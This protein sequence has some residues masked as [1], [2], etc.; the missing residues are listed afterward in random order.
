MRRKLA[1][2]FILLTLG[3]WGNQQL[4]YAQENASCPASIDLEQPAGPEISIA[5]VTFSGALH[6]PTSDQNAIAALIEE[7]THGTSLDDVKDEALERAREGWQDRGYFKAE[8]TAEAKTLTSSPANQRIALTI[9]VDE[10]VQYT[11]RS[12]TFKNNKVIKSVASL[13]N[14]FQIADG[15][16]LDR[17]KIAAGL[18]RLRDFY[19]QLGY[20]NFTS[21]PNTIFDDENKTASLRIDI[22][23]SKQFYL[24]AV[25]VLGLDETERQEFLNDLPMKSGEIFDSRLWSKSL[26]KYA[27]MLPDCPCRWYETRH[28]DEHSATIALTFDFRPCAD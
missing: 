22:D 4:C 2:I 3:L 20:L 6:L 24:G 1:H 23:E 8:V 15:D 21:I 18:D 14:F 16:L 25:N 28:V 11:L 19:G 17:E 9:H 27:S 12:I 13:R 10:G 7:K 26:V 5:D